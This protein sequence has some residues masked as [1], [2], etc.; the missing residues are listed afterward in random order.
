VN[1]RHAL[2]GARQNEASQ[3]AILDPELMAR[4][5]L[6]WFDILAIPR[7]APNADSAHLFLYNP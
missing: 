4:V 7:D 5:A 1:I 3:S 2:A 6:L